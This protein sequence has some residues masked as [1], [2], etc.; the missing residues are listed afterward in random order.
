M[1]RILYYLDTSA[2]MG[3][4]LYANQDI[5]AGTVISQCEVLVLSPEDTVK[6]NDTDLKWYTF[7]YSENQDCLV[8]GDGEIFN[9]DDN[10]NVAYI[11]T[12]YKDETCPRKLMTFVAIKDIKEG[13]QLFI[14]Y[15]ADVKVDSKQ[16]TKNLI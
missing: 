11:L 1:R 3:R 2:E 10:A 7:K 13:S 8:L 4:G 15:A 9:H 14:D 12:E 6:A 16:Y 5:K